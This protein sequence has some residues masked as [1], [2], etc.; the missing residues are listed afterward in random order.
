LLLVIAATN[1]SALRI[2]IAA[3]AA[4]LQWHSAAGGFSASRHLLTGSGQTK[5]GVVGRVELHQPTGNSC[6]R[7]NPRTNYRARPTRLPALAAPPPP[8]TPYSS[9][10]SSSSSLPFLSDDDSNPHDDD[11]LDV[12]GGFYDLGSAGDVYGNDADLSDDYYSD[13]PEDSDGDTL[14]A[15]ISLA[16]PSGGTTRRDEADILEEREDRF[17]SGCGTARPKERCVLVG[18]EDL[19]AIRKQA[20]KNGQKRRLMMMTMDGYGM[21]N[22]LAAGAEEHVEDSIF[23]LEESLSEMRELIKTAGLEIGGEITQRLPE[24]NPRTYMNSGKVEQAK[25]LLSE[26][27]CTTIVF[28]AELSPGQQKTLENA[29][30]E[31]LI[32]NDFRGA[33]G[34]GEVKVLDRT[35]LILDIF[36][37]HAKTREG[38]LQVDLALHEY[39]KP[40][41]TR[42][43]THLERQS[44]AGGASGSV[45]LRGPGESQLQIDKRLVRDRIIVLKRRLDALQEQR[46]IRR[47]GRDRLGLPVLALVGYTN[48]G[49][50]T[51][52]N[53]LTR[54]G[55]MAESMLFA[56]LDPTTRKVKLPG[57]KTHPEVLLTDT[58]GFIQ[59][60]PTHLVAAFRAT[61][62]EVNTADVL[63]HVIDISNPTWRKQERAVLSVLSDIGA[64]DK[65]VVRVLNKVDLLEPADAEYL[66][67]EAAVAKH[68]V[69]VSALHGDGVGDLVACIEEALADLLVPIEVVIPYS[70]GVELNAVHEQGNVE[71]VDHRADG[72]YVRALVPEAVA[73][74]LERYRVQ[75]DAKKV[76]AKSQSTSQG[77][78]EIDWV[79]L[80]RGRH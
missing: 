15:D 38:K 78:N 56:T 71:V 5:N 25:E 21:P 23:T 11:G 17:Y 40:R 4:V 72:T 9:S 7:L 55:V 2:T 37:Q 57:L 41:L 36:A 30:N 54:A 59:K 64:S 68:T 43:W 6:P 77:D 33:A 62:E 28:D 34:I 67:Y 35:A 76:V 44:G 1:M 31:R 60:L 50:S 51:C 22:E 16:G 13:S 8:K 48:S 3:L 24:L 49:K 10:S 26:T 80:G 53:Y 66:R 58:V 63:V 12:S 61:L 65:P 39:R 18:V 74:R 14:L 75:P 20:K 29:F 45:G 47:Q 69:A 46:A 27:G 79:A 42:M 32:E 52:L 70:K 19:G 73:N